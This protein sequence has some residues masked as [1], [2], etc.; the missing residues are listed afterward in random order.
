LPQRASFAFYPDCRYPLSLSCSTPLTTSPALSVSSNITK[1]KHYTR[2]RAQTSLAPPLSPTLLSTPTPSPSPTPTHA[3]RRAL[4]CIQLLLVP[5]PTLPHTYTCNPHRPP[6]PVCADTPAPP[7]H[8]LS[9]RPN[10]CHGALAPAA[11]DEAARPRA[12]RAAALARWGRG[13]GGRA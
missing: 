8:P 12:G 2:R 9:S 13:C 6:A 10:S 3:P 5:T 1:T 11:H 4:A 7:P